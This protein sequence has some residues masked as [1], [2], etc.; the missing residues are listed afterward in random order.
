[1]M[2]T[3]FFIAAGLLLL[4]FVLRAKL[5]IL[6]VL[7][8]PAAVSGGIIGLVI[9]SFFT[10]MLFNTELGARDK[11]GEGVISNSLEMAFR[12]HGIDLST[13]ARVSTE[14]EDGR[15]FISDQSN[16]FL[17]V[18][19]ADRLHIYR[20][21]FR[22]NTLDI[23]TELGTW[24][25]WLIAVIFSGLLLERPGKSFRNSIKLATREGIVVWII[26][27]GEI[28]LG[29]LATWLVIG[30]FYDVPGSFGQL[31]EVGFAGGHGTAAAMGQIFDGSLGFP[32]GPDLAYFFATSGLIFGVVSGIAYINLAVR[33]GWT[34]SGNVGLPLLT[35]LEARRTPKA[36]GMGKVRPE[37]I[38]PL[39]F[40]SLIIAAAFVL[41]L[42]IQFVVM[43][44]I[45]FGAQLFG[46]DDDTRIKI[47]Q[48]AGN[49]PLFMFTLFAGLL[50]RETMYLLKIGDLIDPDSLRRITGAAMEFLI[51]AAIASMKLSVL[52]K[53]KLPILI[54]LLLGFIWTGF[55]LLFI[56]RRLL[57]KDYW[58]ELGILNYG[59][60]TG[61]T[62][63]GL[64]LLRIIDKDLESG[65][66][67]DYALAAPL[68]APFVGGGVITL[69]L[70]PWLLQSDSFVS[71]GFVALGFIV[72]IGTL[73][74][75]GRLM[76]RNHG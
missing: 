70:L 76:S 25:G 37:V 23:R 74:G 18:E 20:V 1:M 22:W 43:K 41:G 39:V 68:S 50:V 35:G 6:Q 29:L 2:Q 12:T 65:A 4:G 69:V 31:I 14:N 58:F 47:M 52:A 44:A 36:I 13:N 32:D 73:Y 10:P 38:D 75:L 48:F 33:R 64:M 62:A 26:I 21:R 34:R 49:M 67:E 46:A 66:A 28:T 63:Q 30:H 42:A 11:L 57:P 19:K 9:L 3:A 27:L 5:R 17:V 71:I 16:A 60:S 54:L 7:Y 55:C 72:V 8:I 45:P 40:Q 56:A 61:T 51:V 53:Y 59:M 15:W 24:P